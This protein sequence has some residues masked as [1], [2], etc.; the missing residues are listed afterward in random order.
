M[1]I[2]NPNGNEVSEIILPDGAT[3]SEVIAPDGS[4]V[5]SG[6]PDSVTSRPD[7]DNTD[8][9][10]SGERGVVIKPSS[11]FQE[12]GARISSNTSGVT[13]AYLYEGFA[14]TLLDSKDISNL[15]TGDAFKLQGNLTAGE[16]Y[17]IVV[18]AEG[19]GYTL[20]FASNTDNTTYSGTDID[21][22]NGIANG[23]SNNTQAVN[24]VGNPDNVLGV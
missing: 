6:I 3:A 13:R 16:N 15:S 11:D 4:T 9:S 2:F 23:S 7:D 14:V 8:T 17:S 24:D 1:P 18:S 12:V 21:I 20:G 22:I 10:G 5:F 19:A